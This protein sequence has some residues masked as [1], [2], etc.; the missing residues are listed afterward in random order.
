[1]SDEII[2]WNLEDF[3]SSIKD[4]KIQATM[5][6]IN[7]KAEKFNQ[8]VKG[9]LT[10]VTFTPTQL[11]EWFEQYEEIGQ[12]TFYLSVYSYL[13]FSTNSQD[14][15]IKAFYSKIDE[16]SSKIQE[17]ILFF[18]LELNKIPEDKFIE[19]VQSEELKD[20]RHYLE[21]N[22]K[23]K[24]HQ[25]S[26]KEEQIILLKDLVGSKAFMKLYTEITSAFTFEFELDGEMKTLTGSQLISLLQHEDREVRKRALLMYVE[27]YKKNELVLT[28]IYNN[29][30]KDFD[31]ETKKR[32]Y[33]KPIQ[34][35]NLENEVEDEIVEALE[36]A[37]T[38]SYATLVERYYNLKRKLLKLEDKLHMYDIY[39]PVGKVNKKYSYEEAI[40]LIKEATNKFDPEFEEIIEQMVNKGH[41]DLTPRKGK[42]GG[43]YCHY[44][45]LKQLPFV[46]VNFTGSI[47][48]VLTLAHELGHAIHFYYTLKNQNYINIFPTIPMAEIASVFCEIMTFDHLINQDLPKEEKITLLCEHLEGNFA[49]SHR[50]N[51]FYRFEK[52]MHELM[53]E[54]LPTTKDYINIFTKEVQSMFGNSISGIEEEYSHYC[55]VIS[56]FLHT[57]FYVYAY[58]MS[59][60]M[61]IALYQLYL[62]KG[63]DFFIPRYKKLLSA[64]G[65]KTPDELLKEFDIDLKDASFWKKGLQYLEDK[66]KEIESLMS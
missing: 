15:E 60:L 32:Q 59:N 43:A 53:N 16:F 14:D 51:A 17:K 37:T 8:E 44:G 65:S 40:K 28:H 35:R 36:E 29:V 41:I 58:N 19:L 64:G 11:K 55:F 5:D 23:R 48:S 63:K 33:E 20:Y 12:K 30:I 54:R 9:K 7:D 27:E 61:V 22:R 31:L 50:Q 4:P 3:Y 34:L 56:H 46:F 10:E 21:I 45:K 66:I 2:K 39:A 57:P 49:T 26:E 62:E 18:N 13:V 6:E 25:L 52:K 42:E 1:M 38:E 47:D 24:K